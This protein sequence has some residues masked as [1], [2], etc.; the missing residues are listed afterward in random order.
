M[1][2]NFCLLLFFRR[3][4]SEEEVRQTVYRNERDV[5]WAVGVTEEEEE[6]T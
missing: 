5:A 2:W 4:V 3:C 1:A 6:L